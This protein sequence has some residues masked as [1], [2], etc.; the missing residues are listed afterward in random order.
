MQAFSQLIF[1]KRMWVL[2]QVVVSKCI[3]EHNSIS[4]NYHI[5]ENRFILNSIIYVLF[6]IYSIQRT[7][8][9]TRGK[10]CAF[11]F[12]VKTHIEISEINM[13]T[14]H[15]HDLVIS[16]SELETN[17]RCLK[18]VWHYQSTSSIVPVKEV[19]DK[20]PRICVWARVGGDKKEKGREPLQHSIT[21]T[22]PWR[23][24]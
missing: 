14:L 7:I 11:I 20:K 13:S 23:L 6:G 5:I 15:L 24:R 18:N 3:L 4:I 8:G 2:K 16:W 1:S 21:L 19:D 22:I 10:C 17:N 9:R 12:Y